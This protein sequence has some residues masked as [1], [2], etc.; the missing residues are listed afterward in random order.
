MKIVIIGGGAAGMSA[1]SKAKRISPDDDVEVIEGGSFVSYAECGIPYYLAGKFDDYKKLIHYPIDEFTKKRNINVRIKT[2]V[3]SID[4]QNRVITTLDGDNI[5]F[6]K[7]VICTGASARKSKFS[8]FPNVFSV[9]NLD[10]AI[11]IKGE[12]GGKDI[13][14]I[15]DGIL[16]ME[17]ASEFAMNEKNVT[18]MSKHSYLFPKL[19]QNVVQEMIADFNSRV[20]VILNSEVKEITSANSKLQVQ[21]DNYTVNVDSVFFTAG[22]TPN[23]DFLKN[24][25]IRID[26][27]GLI[28]VNSRM[29]TNV[30][31]VY[32]AG[33]CATSLNR[34]TGRSEWQPL[35]Q[36]ANKMGRVAGSNASGKIMEFKGG[37]DTTLLK[38]FDYEVGLCGFNE[39][40]AE[41]NGF[42]PEWKIV[43]GK[44]RA[45]Y[46]DGGSKLMVKIVYD[47]NTLKLLGGQ[48]CSKDNGA[49]RLN[50]LETAIFAGMTTEDL[51]YNDLGYTPP[52]GPV[53]DPIIIAASLTM[54]D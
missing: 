46:Y 21:S 10:D 4:L 17:L 22:I 39:K 43:S 36:I 53:W 18:L 50:T 27:N 1:A 35:A 14:V 11:R 12:N 33:D 3:M 16:G 13:L 42:S 34:I 24:S 32:A 47:K 37:L 28:E 38:I 30:D 6:D 26:K 44:S 31:G 51:F 15:G 5:Q 23:T 49:W 19:D 45:N 9:R 41:E 2:K 29:E 8:N 54:R 20:K 7:L 25:G 48:I 40:Q 52:F